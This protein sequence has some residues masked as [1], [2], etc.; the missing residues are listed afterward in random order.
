MRISG[1]IFIFSLAFALL[2]S[3]CRNGPLELAGE[4]GEEAMYLSGR[5]YVEYGR[6]PADVDEIKQFCRKNNIVIDFDSYKVLIWER[7]SDGYLLK[8]GRSSPITNAFDT[9][10]G[11]YVEIPVDDEMFSEMTDPQF[12]K[13]VEEKLKK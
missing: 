13:S 11:L 6:L 7:D 5:Y 2:F 12:Q 1:L 4:P 3:G 8:L 10:Q 9:D